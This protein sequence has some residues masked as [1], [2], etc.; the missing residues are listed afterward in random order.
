MLNQYNLHAY[1][2]A[3]ELI[4]HFHNIGMPLAIC[5]GSTKH[6]YEAKV[7][8]HKDLFS[9]FSHVVCA[10]DKEVKI[11]KP[12]PDMYLAAARRFRNRPKS[13]RNVS[14]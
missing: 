14:K 3:A 5:T 2:G 1:A 7:S 6:I 10:D 8:K 9:S 13:S 12:A 4:R 11:G